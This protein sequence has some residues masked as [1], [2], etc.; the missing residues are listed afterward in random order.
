MQVI[1]DIIN[2]SSDDIATTIKDLLELLVVAVDAVTAAGC[3]GDD[4]VE[5]HT[6][7]PEARLC[8]DSSRKSLGD[9]PTSSK[10][11]SS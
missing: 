11:R 8:K 4:A 1:I 6:P 9:S 5:T 7:T 3:T 2:N 10:D